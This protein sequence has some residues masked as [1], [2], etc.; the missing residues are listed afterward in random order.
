LLILMRATA[1]FMPQARFSPTGRSTAW[2]DGIAVPA[3]PGERISGDPSNTL[4]PFAVSASSSSFVPRS[5]YADLSASSLIAFRPAYPL[6]RRLA[7]ADFREIP[8]AVP[9]PRN[10]K[11]LRP[12][13]YSPHPSFYSFRLCSFQIFPTRHLPI[14]VRHTRFLEIFIILPA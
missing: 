14:L 3:R 2:G 8:L 12:S 1:S 4:K 5:R 10:S 13:I 11:T 9:S 7:L 6:S